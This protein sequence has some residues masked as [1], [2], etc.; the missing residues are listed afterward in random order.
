MNRYVSSVVG[1]I[2]I[3]SQVP[4]P[5]FAGWEA[6]AAQSPSS[7][8]FARRLAQPIPHV[9]R[10]DLVQLRCQLDGELAVFRRLLN[11]GRLGC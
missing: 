5:A 11:A 1:L 7:R 9:V 8:Y 4:S 2:E 10:A 3:E 6:P